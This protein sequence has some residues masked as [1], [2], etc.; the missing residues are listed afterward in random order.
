MKTIAIFLIRFYQICI[1]PLLAPR[2]RFYPT[3]SQYALEAVKKYGFLKGTYLAT[4]RIL[5][6]HPFHKAGMT[7]TLTAAGEKEKKLGILKFVCAAGGFCH[8]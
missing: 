6:C 5:K 1:S 7:G 2:C 8:L 3:C 4:K